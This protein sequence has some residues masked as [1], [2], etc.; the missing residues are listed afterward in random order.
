[1]GLVYDPV[2]LEHDTGAHVEN[3][4]RITASVE[5]LASAGLLEAT[6]RIPMRPATDDELALV[7]A[8]RYI[9][10]LRQ[11]AAAG[12]GWADP[13]TL[14]TP[15]SFD[16]AARVAGGTIE[17][18]DAVLA[19]RVGS[20]FCLVR[21]PGHHATPMQA[22]GFCL[23]NQVAIAAAWA[24]A[25][26][27]VARVAIV[28]ID[29]HHGNGTQDAFYA[30]PSVLYVSTHEYPFYPGTGG[31]GETGAGEGRGANMN[32]PL[33]A[34]CGDQAYA[35]AFE[36]VV[37][38]ALR[39]F[40]PDLLLVSAGF[41]AHFADPLADE[42]LSVD[43]YGALVSRLIDAAGELCDGR[44]L[45]A[46]EGGYDLVAL[47]WCVRRALELMLG[48]APSPDPLG[49]APRARPASEIEPLVAELRALH[50]L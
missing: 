9:E 46:L 17:A 39:R 21:P 2:V 35:R 13:D 33:P 23:F 15:R 4:Q 40:R 47:P 10:A 20:A 16:V 27:D 34:G 3:G 1:V 29:V 7:H 44:L 37:L 43:G 36:A 28:D 41:D 8:P 26:R 45:L 6:T 14:I 5:L 49:A 48:R 11:A 22:M 38:P 19:G 18:V 31:A 42:R 12:G 32:I 24:R 30:D 25:K 50:R